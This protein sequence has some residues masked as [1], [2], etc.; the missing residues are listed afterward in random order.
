MA[1][2][3]P[4]AKRKPLDAI[5]YDHDKS[6]IKLDKSH[7]TGKL[8]WSK[9][10]WNEADA[11]MYYQ[12]SLL[13]P[14]SLSEADQGVLSLSKTFLRT[15]L[16]S[17]SYKVRRSVNNAFERGQRKMFKKR[18]SQTVVTPRNMSRK[19]IAPSFYPRGEEFRKQK[20]RKFRT[21]IKRPLEESVNP[22][23]EED[24]YDLAH[25]VKRTKIDQY[26]PSNEM[27]GEQKDHN[28]TGGN[29]PYHRRKRNRDSSG[30]LKRRRTRRKSRQ[31]RRADILDILAPPRTY[32]TLD[33]GIIAAPTSAGQCIV[34]VL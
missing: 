4:N 11:R 9:T 29:M 34:A 30:R 21:S 15:K 33:S 27:G 5:C 10:H 7:K 6:Y 19:R 2:T 14:R 26:L 32:K 20:S 25:N 23:Y 17:A 12:L 3:R 18:K 28:E 22:Y 24:A 8:S 31:T 13:D 1:K 16:W